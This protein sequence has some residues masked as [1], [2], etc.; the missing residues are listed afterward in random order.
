MNSFYNVREPI[1]DTRI[2]KRAYL[3]VKKQWRCI[4][5]L[6]F[7]PDTHI[8]KLCAKGLLNPLIAK[9]REYLKRTFIIAG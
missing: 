7:M 3:N 1:K 8:T 6:V 9:R 2:G 5:I 4:K